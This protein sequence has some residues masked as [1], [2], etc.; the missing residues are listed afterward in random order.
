MA[1]VF[2][3]PEAIVTQRFTVIAASQATK[4]S[5]LALCSWIAS[6]R[7]RRRGEVSAARGCAVQ[8]RSQ[9]PTLLL[10]PHLVGDL[11]GEAQLGPLLFLAENVAFLGRGEA[12][13]RRQR[14]LLQRGEFCRFLQ[15]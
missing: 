15:P 14:Q 5:S 11:D 13:L 4:Q 6:L 3:H 12:A 1:S 8:R 7:S 2:P 9:I 10:A